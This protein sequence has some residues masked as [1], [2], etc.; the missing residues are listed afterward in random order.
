M[1]RQGLNALQM[2]V[3]GLLVA[4]IMIWYRYEMIKI[5]WAPEF[6]FGTLSI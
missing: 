4:M 5:A 6:S 1:Y 2:Q 3:A